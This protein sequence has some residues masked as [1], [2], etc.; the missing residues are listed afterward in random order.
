[1]LVLLLFFCSGATA[2]VYEVI[3]SKYL[4]LMLGSTVQAQTVVLA[5]FMGG[6]A[7]GN[8]LFGKYS[9]S[10]AEPLRGYAILEL[11]I[12]AYG[13]SFPRLFKIADAIF[14]TIGSGVVNAPVLPLLVKLFICILLLLAPT[15]LMGGTL[16]LLAAWIQRQSR[17]DAAA[18]VGIFYAVNSLGAVLGAGL[19]GFFFVQN[20]GLNSGLELTGL[21][22]LFVGFFAVILAKRESLKVSRPQAQTAAAAEA[23]PFERAPSGAWFGLLVALT[24]GVSMGLEVAFSRA[25]AMIAGGSL[26]SFS[27]VLMSFIFGI[28]LGSVI[29]S[30]SGLAKR[31]GLGTIYGLLILAGSLV[32]VHVLFIENI[33]ILYAQA[34][35]GLAPNVVG[36]LWHELAI[37]LLALI[38]LGFPA[39]CLGAVVPLAIRLSTSGSSSLGDRVGRLL[40]ANTIGAVAGVLLTGFILMPALGLR[41]ALAALAI[42]LFAAAGVIAFQRQNSAVMLLSVLF[43]AGAI[44]GTASTGANWRWVMSAGVFR[45]RNY[46][47]TAESMLE[48]RRQVELLFYKDSADATVSVEKAATNNTAQLGLRINGKSDAST[49]GDAGTQ[50]LLAHLP[51]MVRPDAT[52]VFVLGFGS[53]ITAGALLGHPIQH[54]TIAE[55]C[56][57]VLEAGPLFAAWNR[58]VLTNER[59]RIINDDARSALKLRPDKY[60][61]IISEPSNP[62]VV[63][64]GSVFSQDFYR[65]CTNRLAENGVMGQWFHNYE[66][67]DDIILL[68]FRTFASVFPNMEIWDTQEG[69]IVLLGSPKPW[70]SDPAQY[71]AVFDRVQPA[72]DLAALRIKS[73]NVLWARQI[74]SQKTASAIAGDGPIQTDDFLYLEYAAPKAFF[75]G[76]GAK[77]FYLFDERTVQFALADRAK[78]AT[79]RAI[80][81]QELFDTFSF[82]STSSPD[83][84]LYLSHISGARN[85]QRIDP[86]GHIIFRAPDSYP[87]D[88]TIGSKARTEL[89][90]C[91]KSEAGLLRDDAHWKTYG[92]KIEQILTGMIAKNDIHPKDFGPQYFAAL[93]V[94]SAIGHD[95]YQSA[96]RALRLGFVFNSNDE[97]LTFL[98]RVLDRV[99]PPD[100]LQRARAADKLKQE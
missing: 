89:I 60:D 78:I 38:L 67:A 47:I 48:R 64:V 57:P 96:L 27:L 76:G 74:A 9:A 98:S 23:L 21:F 54:L 85:A 61:V 45:T 51:M 52:N 28:G 25:L 26:Q 91:V 83:L 31:F 44:I 19:A 100:V 20:F 40:T 68:I 77:H 59:T 56:K 13:F 3:W 93:V 72:K 95:D 7:I 46:Y 17:F 75:L 22:N 43:L 16:P 6:L 81:T 73:P 1:M 84:L 69:D 14:V 37:G 29:I 99:V 18:R 50:F 42:L 24:G 36:Y 39:A 66:M 33:A 62:W 4:T 35:F 30:S 15:I 82:Y 41:T 12:G 11:I 2:L 97:Q 92:Q 71:Q 32:I 34:K 88:P 86:M 79:L 53:G 55:N 10:T 8:R 70:R 80:P 87:E 63:G 49:I 65:L 90:E 58:G 94:R 5:V